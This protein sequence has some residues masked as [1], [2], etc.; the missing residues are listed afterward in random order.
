MQTLVIDSNNVVELQ[1]LSNQS[2][3]DVISDATVRCTIYDP[4]KV[5]V[6]GQ[7][8]PLSLNP[9]GNGLYRG[10]LNSSLIL[11]S[12]QTYRAEVTATAIG[13]QV[14]KWVIPAKAQYDKVM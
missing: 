4:N 10:T 6:V 5:P 7:I 11:K 14:K 2:T 8:W 12:G 3:G 9:I 13:G 1:G